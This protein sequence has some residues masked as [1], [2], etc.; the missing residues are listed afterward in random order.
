LLNAQ[1]STTDLDIV[2][3]AIVYLNRVKRLSPSD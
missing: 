1:K 3:F 2:Y